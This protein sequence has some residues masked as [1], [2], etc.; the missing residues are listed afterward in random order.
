MVMAAM[1]PQPLTFETED[2]LTLEGEIRMPDGTR[3][4]TAVICHP[5]PT[6]GGS[7]DHPV[8]WAI[9][10]E[11]AQRGF[12]V[13]AFNFRGVMG[14]E[15]EFGGGVGEVADARAAIGAAQAEAGGPTFVVGWSFGA[16]VAMREAMDDDRV[17]G[18]ALVA[19]PTTDLE[20][21]PP[22]GPEL[23]RGFGRPVLL[24]S[25]SEDEF[26][27]TPDLRAMADA[28]PEATLEILPGAGHYFSKRERETGAIVAE[29]AKRTVSG[30]G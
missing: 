30:D 15:G 3:R 7:K 22:P 4:A 14:S 19:L 16:N 25:G 5:L 21:P 27:L 24:V 2:G 8:L 17:A 18:L 11:L 26:S 29:F 23:L 10:I 6:A 13:L 12:A 1:L 9:R 20:L 28:L